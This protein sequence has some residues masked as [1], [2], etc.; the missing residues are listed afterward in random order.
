[1]DVEQRL[2]DLTQALS[3]TKRP[4]Q[5]VPIKNESGWQGRS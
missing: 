4:A 5:F 2:K 1:M 3:D